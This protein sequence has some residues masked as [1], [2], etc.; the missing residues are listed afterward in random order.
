MAGGNTDDPENM[1]VTDKPSIE[2]AVSGPVATLIVSASPQNRWCEELLM[3]FNDVVLELGRDNT[4]RCLIV[5]GATRGDESWFSA[6]LDA[7]ALTGDPLAGAALSRLFGQAFGALR[8][9]PGVTIAAING[10]ALNEGIAC[11]LSCD[12]RIAVDSAM[13]G[14]S[15]GSAGL[16]PLGGSTQ[17]LPRLIGESRAKRMILAEQRITAAEA[18]VEGLVDEIASEDQL[19]GRVEVLTKALLQQSPM[20]TRGAKQLI[21]HARM[22]PLETGFAAEREWQVQ[23]IEGGD[24]LEARRARGENQLPEWPNS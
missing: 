22:R 14:Y 3:R 20:A 19:A 8:R 16:L 9:F 7:R 15:S 24:Y 21:E 6:G 1:L 12:F 13:F 17:L 4:V 5:T 23:V 11:A 18:L 10:H 2:V